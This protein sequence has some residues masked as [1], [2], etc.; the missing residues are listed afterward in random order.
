MAKDKASLVQVTVS[1]TEMPEKAVMSSDKFSF[2]P[3]KVLYALCS[4]LT[5][6]EGQ[7]S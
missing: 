6:E 7:D 1:V 4:M 3:W 2:Q 5:T